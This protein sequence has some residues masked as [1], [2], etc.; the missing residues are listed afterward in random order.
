MLRIPYYDSSDGR[1][2]NYV[3]DTTAQQYL[4]D[5]VA[6]AVRRSNGRI[7]RLY[8]R[9]RERVYATPRDGVSGL[10]SASQTTQ[11]IRDD[12]GVLIAPRQIQEHRPPQAQIG[13]PRWNTPLAKTRPRRP[14]PNC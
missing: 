8:Q 5:G 3:S 12:D 4:S 2:L 14:L 7:A 13:S 10:H 6:C 11:R 9:G 1:L